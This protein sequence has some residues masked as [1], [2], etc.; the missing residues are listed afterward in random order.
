MH[1]KTLTLTVVLLGVVLS[2]CAQA[3]E[4]TSPATP[5]V[6]VVESFFTTAMER[7]IANNRTWESQF[8]EPMGVEPG[9]ELDDQFRRLVFEAGLAIYRKM[10]YDYDRRSNVERFDREQHA[11]VMTKYRRLGRVYRELR[12]EFEKSGFLPILDDYIETEIAS[13][14]HISVLAGSSAARQNAMRKLNEYQKAFESQG[15]E[16]SQ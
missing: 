5:E 9:S 16:A 15:A 2:A 13:K 1:L 6:I 12:N 3:S 7:I 8:L 10:P 4:D 11:F 14:G